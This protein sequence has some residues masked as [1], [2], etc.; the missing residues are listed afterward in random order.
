MKKI[1]FFISLVVVFFVSSDALAKSVAWKATTPLGYK[2]ITW[3]SAR[4]VSTFMKAPA[5]NGYLDYLTFV[6]LPYN[7]VKFVAS[8]T[9]KVDWGEPSSP[10]DT[11]GELNLMADSASTTLSMTTGTIR[12]WAFAKMMVEN[13]KDANPGMKF[14]WNV[15][16][17]N[18]EIPV[19]DLS[20]GLKS[21]DANGSYITSGSR[22]A[23]DMAQPRR[24]LIVDNMS[25]TSSIRNFDSAAFISEGDQAVEGFDPTITVKGSGSDERLFLGV[26]PGG[27]E[28]VIYCSQGATPLEA[29]AALLLAGVPVENQLQ[30]DGGGSATCAYNMPG[31]YF[32]APGRTLPHL[33]GAQPIVGRGVVIEKLL[34]VRD[35]AGSKFKIVKKLTAKTPLI[36]YESKSGW[37][38]I[39]NKNEWVIASYVKQIAN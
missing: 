16:F 34:N 37:L 29:S 6:Y 19:T 38:R 12:D 13:M 7:Q 20:M 5:A 28:L 31:Q 32:V 33:M 36:I 9:P 23:F 8:S 15:P 25:G 11:F 3:A 4:G 14:F 27:K 30:A 22:P 24:M 39:S 21:E 26:K 1:I 35:G 18:V 10:F 2:P 17:F